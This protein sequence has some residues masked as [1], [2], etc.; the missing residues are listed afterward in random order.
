M[1]F[2]LLFLFGTMLFAL[3]EFPYIKP[4]SVEYPSSFKSLSSQKQAVKEDIEDKDKDGVEDAK[5]RCPD[6]PFGM[7]V[8][9]HGCEVD[10]DDDGV[11]DSKDNCPNTSKEFMVDD[12]G[13][14]TIK[15]PKIQFENDN[16]TIT[17]KLLNEL[18]EFAEFLKQ[19]PSFQVVMYGYTDN[20]KE[21]GLQK[22]LSQKKV[23]AV[24]DALIKLGI[25]AVKLTAIGMGDL[26]PIADNNT[27]QGRAKNNRIDIVLLR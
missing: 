14:P 10:S 24:V 23:Q 8:N 12:S 9:N 11:F 6:T 18:K 13:C 26:D 27:T 2:L 15:M 16:F 4:I 17:D 25:S 7:K 19:N 5:D 21:K 1:K 20:S 3:D 22:K